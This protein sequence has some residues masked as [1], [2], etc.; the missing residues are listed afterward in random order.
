MSESRK[1]LGVASW[2]ALILVMILVG[3]PLSAVP[4]LWARDFM[5]DTAQDAVR[6]IY[7]PLHW[8]AVVL[9]GQG[10]G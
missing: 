10:N 2:T 5:P 9:T 3:Y 1:H 6:A 4:M 7:E 8:L